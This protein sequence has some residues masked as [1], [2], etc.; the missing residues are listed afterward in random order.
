MKVGLLVLLVIALIDAVIVHQTTRESNTKFMS[1]LIIL[2]IVLWLLMGQILVH[3]LWIFG[4]WCALLALTSIHFSYAR[5][6]REKSKQQLASVQ[7][8]ANGLV[9][10][11]GLGA[12]LSVYVYFF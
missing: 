7:F 8:W 6:L 10:V 4:A 9:A 12:L 11:V 2:Y 5:H 3:N 1:E